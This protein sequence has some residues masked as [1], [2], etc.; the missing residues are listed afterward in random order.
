[1]KIIKL[2]ES[3]ILALIHAIE[4]TDGLYA[5]TDMSAQEKREMAVLDR[6]REKLELA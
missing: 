5:G 6:V 4:N 1:M 2:T 3:Q